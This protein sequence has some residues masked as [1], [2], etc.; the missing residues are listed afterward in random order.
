MN[1]EYIVSIKNIEPVTHDV[2]RFRFEKPTGYSFN[3]GQATEVSINK[4]S[5]L[6]VQSAI[7]LSEAAALVSKAVGAN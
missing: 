2:R 7:L 3:P 6:K 4:E 5:G 1:E